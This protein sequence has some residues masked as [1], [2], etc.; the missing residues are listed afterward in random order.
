MRMRV[1][2][3]L[4]RRTRW[5]GPIAMIMPLLLTCVPL[6]AQSPELPSAIPTNPA[7]LRVAVASSLS[8]GFAQQLSRAAVIGGDFEI[9][10]NSQGRPDSVRS[11]APVGT[12][13]F[14][15]ILVELEIW[16]EGVFG[17]AAPGWHRWRLEMTAEHLAPTG[18]ETRICPTS[19]AMRALLNRLVY[20]RSSRASPDS[21]VHIEISSLA[22]IEEVAEAVTSLAELQNGRVKMC[23]NRDCS[24]SLRRFAFRIDETDLKWLTSSWNVR[25]SDG[26]WYIHC[27]PS[28]AADSPLN[29]QCIAGKYQVIW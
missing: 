17:D 25:T 24:G 21:A 1:Q 16:Q 5:L 10:I 26:T 19:S 22:C 11:Q 20:L 2:R 6:V 3:T 29:G 7:E 27:P 14:F 12:G 15:P 28:R 13:W 4:D 18:D 9:W 8:G 23:L